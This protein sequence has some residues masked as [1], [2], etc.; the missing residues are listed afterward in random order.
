MSTPVT[1][2]DQ[3]FAELTQTTGLTLKQWQD[4]LSTDPK[5][6]PALVAGWKVLGAMSWTKTQSSMT[7]VISILN[8]IAAIANPVTAIA[9]GASGI[10]SLIVTLKSI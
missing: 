8:S 1:T 6:Q 10:A 2:E 9:G 4:I 7:T 5:D 3:L